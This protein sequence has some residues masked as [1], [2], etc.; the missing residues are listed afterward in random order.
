MAKKEINTS[1]V[2]ARR[3][4]LGKDLENLTRNTKDIKKGKKGIEQSKKF[5]KQR[6]DIDRDK[7]AFVMKSAR[8]N[9]RRRIQEQPELKRKVKEKLDQLRKSNPS[10]YHLNKLIEFSK[11][12]NSKQR[13]DKGAKR[14]KYK[15]RQN[16]DLINKYGKDKFEMLGAM[17]VTKKGFIPEGYKKTQKSI[18]SSPGKS[19]TLRM[20]TQ[21]ARNDKG[22][23][24][25]L[26]KP[27]VQKKKKLGLWITDKNQEQYKKAKAWE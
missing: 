21:A 13:K 11:K 23:T 5:I 18:S 17:L 14:S 9:Q 26:Q 12:I 10:L 16:T 24:I 2:L 8:I 6:T 27:T 20:I 3:E 1:K 25:Y 22:H 4:A 15:T 7:R 19:N